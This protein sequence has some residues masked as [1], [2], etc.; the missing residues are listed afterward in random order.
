MGS[1]IDWINRL[2]RW[3]MALVGRLLGTVIPDT[4]KAKGVREH[5]REL[6]RHRAELNTI[7]GLLREKGVITQEEYTAR[8]QE[9]S[10]WYCDQL[11]KQFPGFRATDIGVDI[12]IPQAYKTTRGWPP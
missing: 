11:E 5:L 4:P 10:R 2:D 12:D 7:A 3:P 1:P 8:L 9:E 6:L